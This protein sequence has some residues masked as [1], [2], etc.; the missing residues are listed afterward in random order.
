MVLFCSADQ[1]ASPSSRHTTED[2][3]REFIIGTGGADPIGA[4]SVTTPVTSAGLKTNVAGAVKFELL[5]GFYTWEFRS[6]DGAYVDWGEGSCTGN[7]RRAYMSYVGGARLV[8][9]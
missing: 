1:S 8:G 2:G 3:V 7:M 4:I 6:V 9:E 5:P